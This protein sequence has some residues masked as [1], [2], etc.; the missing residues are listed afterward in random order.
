MRYIIRDNKAAVGQYVGEYVAKRINAHFQVTDRPF[1]LGC[2]TGSSPL[3]TYKQLIQIHREGRVSFKNVITF[4]MDEYVA[5]PKSH[6]ESYHSFMW[7]NFF[8]HIDIQ[9]QNVHILDGNAADLVEECSQYEAKIQ[10]VGGIDLFMAGVGSDGHI[11][12]NEPGSSLASRT[13]IK[14]LAYDTV[15]DNSRFF[16]NDPLKVPRMAL[17]VGVQTVMDAREILVII[18]GQH[19]AHALANCV[20]EGVNHMNTV[21]CIQLH[22]NAL[23]VSDEDATS[24][25]R[26]RTVRYFKGIERAQEEIEKLYGLHGHKKTPSSSGSP[27]VGGTIN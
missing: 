24:E 26:V 1:V 22:P 25:L 8:S 4:N 19:K 9:P 2:P 6:P 27:V 7:S 21:S 15:L 18:V 17:T 13:R 12:F 3:D 20:E 16:D 11:A 14:T 10:A 5:L 23:L